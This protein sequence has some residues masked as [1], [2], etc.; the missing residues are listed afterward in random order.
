MYY[1]IIVACDSNFGIGYRGNLP[2]GNILKPDLQYFKKI[3]DGNTVIMGRGTWE[4]IPE[5]F[6]PLSNRINY[7]LT[8]N[9]E[10]INQSENLYTFKYFLE[11]VRHSWNFYPKRNI[12]IIGGQNIYSEALN[13]PYCRYV[14]LTYIYKSYPYDRYFQNFDN[15]FKLLEYSNI[16]QYYDVD[17]QFLKYIKTSQNQELKYQQILYNIYKNGYISKG[18]NGETISIFG[19]SLEF[20]VSDQFPM[21]TTRN[22][23]ARG[24]FEEL[25]WMLRGH[26][27]T[28]LLNQKNIKI[29]NPNSTREF[30]DKQ[31]LYHL[32]EGDIGET[33]GFLFRHFGA[34]YIN[35]NTNYSGQGFDQL[36]DVITKI[37]TNPNNRRII[38]SLWN[39]LSLNN[40]ALPPCVRDYQFYVAE[41]RLSLQISIRSSD[42]PVA[43]HWNI[44][45]AGFFLYLMANYCDLKPDKLRINIGNAHIYM[46]HYNQIKNIYTLENKPFPKL[47]INHKPDNI[48]DYQFSDLS[49]VGYFPNPLAKFIKLDMIA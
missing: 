32:P 31:G 9:P 40:C 28:K 7:I 15:S 41:N 36:Q 2:W 14:Y 4:S 8:S 22:C 6:K 38:I 26:T 11:A 16:Q 27:N 18:R 25:M 45:S 43:L 42:T 35:C 39:P 34:K 23:F 3:T 47:F 19:K 10:K 13:S 29:W 30:L 33:Y 37:K 1:D 49:I 24:I 48:E 20:D 12:F 21:I 5:K 46:T 17:Y 44:C